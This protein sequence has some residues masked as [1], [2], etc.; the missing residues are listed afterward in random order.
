M[1]KT[2]IYG[3]YGFAKEL[4]FLIEEIN[5]YEKKFEILGYL[6]DN[7]DNHGKVVYNYPV[8]GDDEYLNNF[9]E[10]INIV[11]GIGNPRIKKLLDI[12]LRKYDKVK[13]PILIHPNVSISKKVDISEGTVITAGNI[14]TTDITIGR[15]CS[16]N[17]DCTIGH[18]TIIHDYVTL[19][20]STN[21]SGN[22][23]IH[24]LVT[25]GTGSQIIQGLSIGADT[26]IGAGSVV[27]KDIPEKVIAV[28]A[29]AKAIKEHK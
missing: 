29:P 9:K 4:A 18:D 28:G 22:V 7:K 24:S 15:H 23:T 26:F 13:Y 27:T 21:I 19:L 20:P 5:N 17:L 11:F 10:K 16:I 1:E 12:K 2:L 25:I 14:I 3:S 6:D 8:L